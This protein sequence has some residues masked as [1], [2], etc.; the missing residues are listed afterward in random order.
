[1]IIQQKNTTIKQKGKEIKLL[2]PH[3]IIE[4]NV[5]LHQEGYHGPAKYIF[6]KVLN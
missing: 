2:I 6:N 1:M 3:H 5:T 4:V